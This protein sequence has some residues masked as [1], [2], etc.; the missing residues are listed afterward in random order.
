MTKE[1]ELRVSTGV[2][3]HQ[4]PP[5]P[6]RDKAPFCIVAESS[7]LTKQLLKIDEEI[8]GDRQTYA[9]L[10]CAR[11]RGMRRRRV[12]GTGQRV[13][14]CGRRE[15][16]KMSETFSSGLQRAA[17]ARLDCARAKRSGP[18]GGRDVQLSSAASRCGRSARKLCANIGAGRGKAGNQV[19]AGHYSMSFPR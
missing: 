11:A 16:R 6:L 12:R 14:W 9:V 4:L 19:V 17:V 7:Q 3:P 2:L 1:L 15:V 8:C 5:A 13:V 18:R 10:R